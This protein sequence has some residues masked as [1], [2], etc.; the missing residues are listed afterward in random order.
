MAGTNKWKQVFLSIELVLLCLIPWGGYFVLCWFYTER[1]N[2]LTIVLGWS[3][4]LV[5]QIIGAALLIQKDTKR[6]RGVLKQWLLFLIF[7]AL[8]GHQLFIRGSILQ[9]LIEKTV[10][11]AVSVVLVVVL[12][13][14]LGNKKKHQQMSWFLPVLVGGLI[15]AGCWQFVEVYLEIL[16]SRQILWLSYTQAGAV[17]LMTVYSYWIAL[18]PVVSGEVEAV[19]IF[20][21]KYGMVLILGQTFL[22]LSLPGWIYILR[23]IV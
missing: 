21:Q 17:F 14:F 15:A 7:A 20:E 10:L 9:F 3:F 11:D 22:W 12:T 6:N 16:E 23:L 18:Q 2:T 13:L 1:L 8:L 19:D 4:M 5:H